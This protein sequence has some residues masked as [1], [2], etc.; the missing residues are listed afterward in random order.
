[1]FSATFPPDIQALATKLLTSPVRVE[2]APP[3]ATADRIEQLVYFAE[4]AEKRALLSW[5]IGSNDWQQVLVFTRTK[6]GANRLTK[7]LEQ[8]GF[9][10]AAIHGNKS[11]AARTRALADFKQGA[12]RVL[13][14]T[15]VAARGIDINELPHVVN[16]ELPDVPEHYVHRI[17]RT[18]R[19]GNEGVAV[20]LVSADERA[21]LKGIERLLGKQL[22]KATE[23]P[24]LG[25]LPRP[26][27]TR[28]HSD[29]VRGEG[30][31]PH[32]QRERGERR[33]E[34]RG[35][36]EQRHHHG[37]QRPQGAHRA[38]G[39]R[40]LQEQHGRRHGKSRAARR[41]RAAARAA[42]RH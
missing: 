38:D 17:G 42:A 41:R 11:Q 19:A 33:D 26:A 6:H 36:H 35:G 37:G 21:S 9:A 18:G 1:L 31:Q 16:Y 15:D 13:V 34:Q 22:P 30:H 4:K 32:A 8:D 40:E 23:R 14:A 29:H 25:D 3:N 28:P 39:N 5:L 20:S 2:V 24:R 10:A 27:D 7:Q 12:V